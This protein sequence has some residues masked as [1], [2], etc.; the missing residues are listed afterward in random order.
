MR[1]EEILKAE[2]DDLVFEGRNKSYGAYYLRKRYL[3]HLTIGLIV[4][5]AVFMLGFSM[6][7]ILKLFKKPAPPVV[8]KK[9]KITEL[10]E[11]PP[12]DKNTP[13]PPPPDLPPP[14]KTVKFTPPIIKPDEEVREED[15]P[16]PIEEL[17]TVETGPASDN[18]EYDFS[19][20]QQATVVEEEVKPQIFTYVEQMPEF[21]GGQAELM[22]YLQKNIRYPPAARENGIEGR[23]VLQFVV[24]ENGNISDI[25]PLREIGG[26][27]TEEA[28]RVVKSMPPWKPGR[29]NG[30]PVKVYFKL[31]ITFKLGAE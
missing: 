14:P 6:P 20:V 15:V 3:R 19:A 25:V 26:G 24:D 13:P 10:S 2:L 23:V 9:I 11:P 30:Q 4:G 1:P 8:E 12:I 17:K 7:Y 16:P 28:I 31:P 21:P 22:K 27:T 5:T 29:Q 18:V